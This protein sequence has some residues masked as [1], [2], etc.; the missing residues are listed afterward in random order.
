LKSIF[1][2]ISSFFAL[3]LTISAMNYKTNS[4]TTVCVSMKGKE[5][6]SSCS[7]NIESAYNQLSEKNCCVK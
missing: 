4:N 5:S 6:Y 7:A 1:L 3:I 2:L